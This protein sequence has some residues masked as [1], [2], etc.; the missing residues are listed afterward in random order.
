MEGAAVDWLPAAVAAALGLAAGL[1]LALRVRAS[2]APRIDAVPV[3]VR[4]LLGKRDVLIH[5]LQELEDMAGKNTPQQ[6]AEERYALELETARVLMALD[7]SGRAAPAKGK[8]KAE[9]SDTREGAAPAASGWLAQRPALRG[10]LWGAGAM[11]ALGGLLFSV[12]ETATTRPEGGSPTGAAMGDRAAAAPAQD[13]EEEVRIRAAVES[14][15][16]DLDARMALVQLA[17]GRGDMMSVWNETKAILDR[18][19]GHP[20]AIAYQALVRLAM[21]QA[22]VARSMLEKL[23]ASS[24][25][26]LEGYLHLALVQLRTGHANEAEAVMA[27]AEKRFPERAESLKRLLAEMK[28]QALDEGEAPVAGGADPHAGL[29]M[30][31]PAVAAPTAAPEPQPAAARPGGGKSVAGVLEL[32]PSLQHGLAPAAVVYIIARE[33]GASGG[34]PAAVKRLAPVF[35]LRFELSAADSMMGGELP[36]KLRLEARVDGDGDAM[37]RDASDPSA[38][39]DDVALG[40]RDLRL[41]LRR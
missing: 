15:P 4:D 17:L 3:E 34:P 12:R 32:D 20:R 30:P 22:D 24:P 2:R 1:V 29:G 19:P 8:K 9:K 26:V 28:Q 13:S 35:P 18:S 10:F 31:E 6:L 14:N 27:R 21:G 40:A 23:I 41:V 5:Q 11:V 36:A 7:E 39:L 33:A 37:T 25:D 16:D 38:Q